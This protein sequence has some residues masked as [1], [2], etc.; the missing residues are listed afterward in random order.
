MSSPREE[1][2]AAGVV[3]CRLPCTLTCA[4]GLLIDV[5]R[6]F[7]FNGTPFD[8]TFAKEDKEKKKPIK[9]SLLSTLM[10]LYNLTCVVAAA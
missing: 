6:Y 7:A 1:D 4:L 5:I 3:V 8:T 2:T 9:G 10:K